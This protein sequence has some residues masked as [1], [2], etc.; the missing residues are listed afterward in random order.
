MWGLQL[1]ERSAVC[2]KKQKR[3]RRR[4]RGGGGKK[5]KLKTYKQEKERRNARVQ[6]SKVREVISEEEYEELERAWRGNEEK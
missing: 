3:K 4:R 6:L 1:I 5:K 2:S